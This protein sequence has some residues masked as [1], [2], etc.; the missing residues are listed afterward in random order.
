MYPVV[1]YCLVGTFRTT[2]V[3]ILPHVARRHQIPT[4]QCT[5]MNAMKHK[6]PCGKDA[7]E[8]VC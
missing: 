6:E 5:L 8:C 1:Q 4:P 7:D 2:L 3:Q